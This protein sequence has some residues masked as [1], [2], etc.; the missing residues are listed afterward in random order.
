MPRVRVLTF[1]IVI[2]IILLMQLVPTSNVD[3][4]AQSSQE[5]VVRNSSIAYTPH[6]PLEIRN[7]TALAAA[8]VSGT[9][10]E[11][12]PFILEGWNIT[13]DEDIG[14]YIYGTTLYFIIRDCW[15]D[16]GD[17]VDGKSGIYVGGTPWGTA[18]ITRV[19]VQDG[20]TG[21][22]LSDSLNATVSDCI[23]RRCTKGIYIF[24][25]LNNTIRNN[26][27][28]DCKEQAIVGTSNQM[29]I[30]DNRCYQ[31]NFNGVYGDVTNWG[32]GIHV[33]AAGGSYVFNNTC[34]DNWYHGISI[35]TSFVTVIENKVDRSR[36]DG[37]YFESNNGICMNNTVSDSGEYGIAVW[38]DSATISGNVVSRSLIGINF[39]ESP[40]CTVE[41]NRLYEDGFLFQ[42][43]D[44]GDYSSMGVKD[45][46]VNDLPL[47]YHVTETSL[48]I[49]EPHGQIILIDCIDVELYNQN[50]SNTYYGVFIRWSDECMIYDSIMK[51]CKAHGIYVEDCTDSHFENVTLS[52][53]DNQGLYMRFCDT[54][55]LFD[56]TASNNVQSGIYLVESTSVTISGGKFSENT[57]GIHLQDSGSA[58]I[59]VNTFFNNSEYGLNLNQHWST[60][61]TSNS[62]T[63]DG[64][65]PQGISVHNFTRYVDDVSGNMVNGEPLTFYD[66]LEN[67]VISTEHGQAFLTNCTNVTLSSQTCSDTTVGLGVYYSTGCSI[68]DSVC[69]YNSQLGIVVHKSNDTE[70]QDTTCEY[71]R[72]SSIM[73]EHSLGSYISDSFFRNSAKGI[74]IALSETTT[75]ERNVVTDNQEEGVRFTFSNHTLLNDNDCSSNAISGIMGEWSFAPVLVNNLCQLNDMDGIDLFDCDGSVLDNN[76]C[77]KNVLSGLAL[78]SSDSCY[79]TD[80]YFNENGEHGISIDSS[81]SLIISWNVLSKNG[82]FGLMASTTDSCVIS[83]NII[84]ENSGY[85]MYNILSQS[86]RVHHNLFI[87][88]NI[89]LMQAYE[90]TSDF[91]EWYDVY[92]G[93]GNYWSD[94]DGAGPYYIDGT[95]G[96]L[97]IYPLGPAD[98]DGDGVLDEWEIL[99]GLNPY[100]DD[101]DNDNIPDGYE[102]ENGLNATM[103]DSGLDEDDDGLT[104]L[105]EYSLGTSANNSDSDHDGMPDL[106][107]IENYL[108]PLYD[109]SGL[110]P[111][112]DGV[113]NIDEF[114]AGTNP[115]ARA[116]TPP[117]T[118][119]TT[120]PTTPP[121]TTT[122]STSTTTHTTSP[123]TTPTLP[124]TDILPILLALAGGFLAGVIV[125][126]IIMR[127]PW[128]KSEG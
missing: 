104:N 88:N 100:S 2:C 36:M 99:N 55:E 44:V 50:C 20:N 38:A 9:G 22:G 113:S 63:N 111:D 103:D 89:G 110:D 105:E 96:A 52:H 87:D 28:Y 10:D 49:T 1:S 30:I 76:V 6:A 33:F 112:G 125:I 17:S 51:N 61:V 82:N 84:S 123:T 16:G 69:S 101:S 74:Q 115:M 120:S 11:G 45:N 15:I 75:V 23:I 59:N 92:T 26:T 98:A 3:E 128:R 47:A 4:P 19:H 29:N 67:E 5:L 25:G 107:E 12:N 72:T 95:T 102:I 42:G 37:I 62:F 66:G 43:T 83:K 27:I 58:N 32:T 127:K 39:Y 106:W 21:I 35:D 18:V 24:A 60:T 97:D 81:D 56:I 13:N 7:D 41:S 117:A 73:I 116:T 54:M 93:E 124:P 78:E 108:N 122:S 65:L 90:T 34:Y 70:I 118:T 109:D 114:L 121:T 48:S 53:N 77:T 119:K 68:V 64:I 71:S 14:I 46:L 94:W 31:T 57:H 79:I 85:G 80:N 8:A 86:L 40:S 126:A 91:S